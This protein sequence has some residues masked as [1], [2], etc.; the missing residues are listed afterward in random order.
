MVKYNRTIFF[1]GWSL[2][3]PWVLWFAAAYISH[4]PNITPWMVKLQGWLSIAGLTAPVLVATLL[5]ASNNML[6]KDLK[7]RLNQTF[8]IPSFYLGVAV[9][10]IFVSMVVAQ[11]ISLLFGYSISQFH[12]SGQPTF[13]SALFSPWFILLFA[14]VVEEIAWHSYGTDTLRRKF[15]LFNTSLI[16]AAYWVFW[17][18]PLSF[19]KGYFHSNMVAEGWIYP[20]NFVFSLFVFVILMNWLYYK[21]NRNILVTILFH[22]SANLSNELFATHPMSKVIQTT[23]LLMVTV[24]VLIKNETLFF[25]DKRKRHLQILIPSK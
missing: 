2:F 1:Y 25:Q 9:G 11:L 12:I 4:M 8:K 13:T 18:L 7:K 16:F 6:L 20:L 14:P 24:V 22:L 19:I 17:H 3:I 5:F 23:L 15:N 10:L 21:T